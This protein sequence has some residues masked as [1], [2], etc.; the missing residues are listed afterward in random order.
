[1]AGSFSLAGVFGVNNAIIPRNG[2]KVA[3]AVLDFSNAAEI[4]IDGEQIVS[5]GQIEYIQ[6]FF[7]DNSANDVSITFTMS[8]TGQKIVVAPNTQGYYS[9][10]IPN[11]PKIVAEMPQLNNRQVECFFYNVPI[12]SHNWKTV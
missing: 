6:G 1:M 5:L 2:P 4:L 8:T 7:C 3:R 9:L 12:Q 11:N 10:L